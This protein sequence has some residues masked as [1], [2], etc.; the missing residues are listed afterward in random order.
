[1]P[2]MVLAMTT[3]ALVKNGLV[4][5]HF[6]TTR[7]ITDF[8]DIQASLV[9]APSNVLDGWTYNGSTFAP[10]VPTAEEVR[11]AAIDTT[12]NTDATIA[13]L[14]PMTNAQFDTW[15]SANVTTLA[16][17][18]AVLKVVVRVIIRRAV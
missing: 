11:L 2:D 8:P 7:P 15:W 5:S 6:D 10:Y 4:L 14:K 17:A 3:Y 9:V 12:I 1:M 18:L 13:A 16:Q